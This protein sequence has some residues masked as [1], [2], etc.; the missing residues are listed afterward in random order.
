MIIILKEKA[1]SYGRYELA[2]KL[3]SRL[4]E[5]GKDLGNM[6]DEINDASSTLNKNTKPD[7]PVGF[8]SHSDRSI[9]SLTIQYS[10]R[11][12]SEFLIVT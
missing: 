5:M 2:E 11:K 7:D 1:D 6:I 8:P 4:D 9:F 3:S 12:S 10:Y